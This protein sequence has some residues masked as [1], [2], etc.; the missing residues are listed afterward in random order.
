[1][2]AI[3]FGKEPP[4]RRSVDQLRGIEGARVRELYKLLARQYGVAWS[5]RRYD[6]DDWDSSDV[7]NKCI[8]AATA[9]LH[10]VVEAAILAAGYAPAIGFIHTGRP[11]SF[12]YDIADLVRD[13]TVL[14]IA[15]RLAAKAP[16]EPERAVRQACRDLFREMRLLGQLIPLVEEV[17][18][19]GGNPPESPSE[20]SQPPVFSEPPPLGDVGHRS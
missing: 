11:R 3:R 15:F 8:S 12:V 1:M 16:D 5:G 7:P 17:L 20:G 14:P 10:G 6:P 13:D 2:Y 19:A 18:A 9:A 4:Q